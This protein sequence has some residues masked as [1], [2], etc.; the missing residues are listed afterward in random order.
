MP[1][2]L[3]DLDKV[4][5][6]MHSVGG[7]PENPSWAGIDSRCKFDVSR[8]TP[9][10]IHLYIRN[11]KAQPGS[12]RS[13]DML[14]GSARI[15]LEFDSPYKDAK[16]IDMQHGTGS[17]R[18]GLEFSQST[19]ANLTIDNFDLLEV[20]GRGILGMAM[21]VRKKDTNCLYALQSIRKATIP[22]SEVAHALAQRSVLAQIDNPFIVPLAFSFQSPEKLYLLLPFMSG[23]ELF[24]HLNKQG[25]FDVARS[26]LYTAELLCAFE[27]LHSFNVIFRHLKY[28]N[29]FLD[30]QGH[31]AISDFG[32]CKLQMED[33]DDASWGIPEYIAPEVLLGQ[34]YNE[35][36]DW[37]TLGMLLHDMLTDSAPFYDEA[38]E[39]MR[40][41]ILS[42]P[43][44]FP[45]VVPPV[46]RDLLEKLL[47]RNPADRLG[48]NGVAEI[49]DHPFFDQIDWEK[50]RR[51]EYEPAFK[52]NVV[53]HIRSSIVSC[54]G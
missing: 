28:E 38:T 34:G 19:P 26:R 33:E 23:G 1:Y 20:V 52:P 41:K 50:L 18:L 48:A 2:A 54:L 39:E 44:V 17:L 46:V 11:P 5:V 27:S 36:V 29:I 53:C 49:K 42:E 21:Q 14:I 40:R 4:Q 13:Q 47:T 15:D 31:I 45:D 43:L 32:L 10:T 16:L 30:H 6:L 51:R 12:G 8:V 9:L 24:Q 25:C 37:W 7:T 22:R 35:T 3:L